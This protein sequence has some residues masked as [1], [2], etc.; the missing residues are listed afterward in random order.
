MTP[1]QEHAQQLSMIMA[2][3]FECI[4]SGTDAQM[5]NLLLEEFCGM[6][7]DAA[8]RTLIWLRV[9]PLERAILM[10]VANS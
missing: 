3:M 7:Q 2:E 9:D 6:D 4:K 1:E 10:I 5:F 8:L